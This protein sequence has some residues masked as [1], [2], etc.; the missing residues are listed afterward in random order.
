MRASEQ[1]ERATALKARG[2]S[3]RTIAKTLGVSPAWA[4]KL[5]RQALAVRTEQMIASADLVRT[6]E[7]ERL[8]AL[9]EA[10]APRIAKGEVA[11]VDAALR[12]HTARAKLWGLI[13]GDTNIAVQV[14][15]DGAAVGS[16]AEA[17]AHM[18]TIFGQVGPSE[19]TPLI[20]DATVEVPMLE[21]GETVGAATK[22]EVK[23]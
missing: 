10:L 12:I 5:V 6:M 18:R 4:Y 17:N 22:G 3:F 14:N 15:N 20:V 16:P 8:E 1:R 11:A 9:D 23:P 13:G 2:Y 7:L 19:P 21:A